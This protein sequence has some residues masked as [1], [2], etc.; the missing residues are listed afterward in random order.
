[1]TRPRFTRLYSWGIVCRPTTRRGLWWN[2]VT[3]LDLSAR[4][5]R[6]GRRGRT[7]Y[8]PEVLFGLLLYGYA[9]GVF[10]PRKIERATHE[11]VPFRFIAG[12][13]R[14]DREK[15]WRRSGR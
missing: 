13:L 14:P 4:Y 11:S 15:P 1:M 5:A 8:A 12:N 9:T 7:T 2:V 6:Y 3:S 10:I